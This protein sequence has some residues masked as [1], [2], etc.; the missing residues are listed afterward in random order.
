MGTVYLAFVQGP[1]GFD[2]LKVVK[3]LRPDLSADP[4]FLSMFL[5]E[6]RL[7]AR[8]NHPNIV[9]T[10]EADFDGVNY[11]IEMEYLE[12]QSFDAVV[13]RAA[14][15]GGVPLPLALW[16]IHQTLSGLHYA[17]E[18]RDAGGAPLRVVHR[19]VSPHNLMV[20]YE[21]TVKILDF[22][23]AKAANSSAETRTGVVKGKAT[24][25]SP[26]QAARAPVDRRADLFAVGIILW[27]ALTSARIWG[28][29]ED[30]QIFAR[31]RAGD[32]P[33]PRTVKTDLP[34]ALEAICMKALAARR[35]DRY[36]TAAEMQVAI[37]SWWSTNSETRA[38]NKLLG[39]YVAELFAEHRRAVQAEID[40]QTRDDGSH[41]ER[42]PLDVPVLLQRPALAEPSGQLSASHTVARDR[43]IEGGER[44]EGI[45][46]SGWRGRRTFVIAGLAALTVGTFAAV[47]SL[48]GKHPVASPQPSARVAAATCTTTRDCTSGAP[49][50]CA[51]ESHVCVPLESEDCRVLA[52]PEDIGNDATVWFGTLFGTRDPALKS[53]WQLFENA[54]DLARMDFDEMLR[55]VAQ[56]P[57]SPIRR[58]AV[59]ACDDSRDY[60]RAAAHL[61]DVG[62]PAVIGFSDDVELLDLATARFGPRGILGMS[63]T[64]TSAVLSD[65]AQPGG[66]RLLWRTAVSAASWGPPTAGFV[67]D[68]FEP[69][70]RR[71]FS[72]GARAPFRIAIISNGDAVSLAFS[73]SLLSHLSFNGQPASGNERNLLQVALSHGSE[74]D[75]S[76]EAVRRL[77]D[78]QP[79]LVIWSASVPAIVPLVSQLEQKWAGQQGLPTHFVARMLAS[80]ELFDFIGTDKSRRRRFFGLATPAT[81]SANAKF[82]LRYNGVFPEHTTLALS[83]STAY[84]AAYLLAYAANA[85]RSAHVTGADVGAVLARFGQGPA[86]EVGPGQLGAGLRLV[87]QGQPIHLLGATSDLTFD[88]ATGDISADEVLMCIDVDD[89]GRARDSRESGLRWDTHVQ[90]VIGHVVCP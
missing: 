16:V 37:E 70:L 44:G 12:G 41:P 34:E 15:G 60:K 77:I 49:A 3:R 9:Q 48:S 30:D 68:Y 87:R 59:V 40:R 64:N 79:H 36:A 69:Q 82:V 54:V 53:D 18:L 75:A 80:S 23:I 19:D 21:G 65:V 52:A 47:A 17:H 88:S 8:L 45:T 78:F 5:D 38:T 2:K 63:A 27:Q 33:S 62:V 32:I 31:L 51:V 6:A 81:I 85:V 86:I 46:T 29:L 28:D 1:G 14:R 76:P 10:F 84:D 71:T 7:C 26:E 43:V 55:G 58:F 89:Q 24:Y 11:Y 4:H 56:D 83:P 39:D 22:G 57:E 66:A 20:T 42:G 13:R 35:E 25:M 74:A 50:T 90:R 67:S 72:L 73:D 61:V